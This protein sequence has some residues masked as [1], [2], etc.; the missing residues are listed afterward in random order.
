MDRR[1]DLKSWLADVGT[2]YGAVIVFVTMSFLLLRLD[3]LSGPRLT[4][5]PNPPVETHEAGIYGNFPR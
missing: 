2:L 1:D 3:I 4:S 5:H